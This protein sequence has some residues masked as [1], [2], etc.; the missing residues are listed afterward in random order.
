MI[1]NSVKE[2][3]EAIQTLSSKSSLDFLESLSEMIAQ[4]YAFGG[5]LLIAGNGGSLCDAMHFAEELTG[6]FRAPRPALPAIALADPG[7]MSCVANDL[8]FDAVFARGIEAHGKR[9]DLFIAL[10]TSGQSN[11]LVLALLKAKELGLKTAAFL[12]RGGGKTKGIADLEW[13]VPHF[14]HSDRIQEVHMAAIHIV[15]EKVEWRV[16]KELGQIENLD[17]RDGAKDR[18]L[19]H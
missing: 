6:F 16:I 4:T 14:G 2:A 5:K 13:I 7:H 18:I 3:I 8:S 12:G 1:K 10:S 9:E 17:E 15:I 11:N 19:H